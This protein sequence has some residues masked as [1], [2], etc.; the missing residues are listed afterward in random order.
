MEDQNLVE[1][2]AP[3]LPIGEAKCDRC[4]A[5]AYVR[6]VV[7]LLKLHWL[8]FCRHHFKVHEV[9]IALRG[10]DWEDQSAQ[11]QEGKTTN[12]TVG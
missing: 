5:D 10:Y 2:P 1:F 6:V 4:C 7:N 3:P 8:D 11:I 12:G 9:E